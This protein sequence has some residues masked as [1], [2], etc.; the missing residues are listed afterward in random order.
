MH[1]IALHSIAPSV[2]LGQFIH[3]DWLDINACIIIQL[4]TVNMQVWES[5]IIKLTV[6]CKKG[7]F[8]RNCE[9]NANWMNIGKI[10]KIRVTFLVRNMRQNS[11]VYK[12]SQFSF[13][14]MKISWWN[15]M[16]LFIVLETC[17]TFL[18]CTPVQYFD[19][20]IAIYEQTMCS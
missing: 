7:L 4:I 2:E 12:L 1:C 17:F 8:A 20:L 3:L 11:I 6:S 15:G 10:G 19:S 9:L 5:D 18:K 16:A 14:T 13:R